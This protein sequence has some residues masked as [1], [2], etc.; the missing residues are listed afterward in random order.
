VSSC[1]RPTFSRGASPQPAETLAESCY[2][3]HSRTTGLDRFL[4]TLEGTGAS[5]P[6]D[7]LRL[8]RTVESC[9][10]R[11]D[12][13]LNLERLTQEGVRSC[14]CGFRGRLPIRGYQ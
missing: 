6:D 7:V 4:P 9:T 13:I 2:R 14:L 11:L 5:S 3:E 12:E 1:R 10:N 8:A